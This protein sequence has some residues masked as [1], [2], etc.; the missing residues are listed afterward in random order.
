MRKIKFSKTELSHIYW[1]DQTSFFKPVYDTS[2]TAKRSNGTCKFLKVVE[3]E[4]KYVALFSWRP[5]EGKS[6]TG[7]PG[8]AAHFK[9]GE[10]LEVSLLNMW[11][12]PFRDDYPER[13][14]IKITNAEIIT[15]DNTFWWKYTFERVKVFIIWAPE[16]E[17]VN[18]KGES[19]GM[20]PERALYA[21]AF[22]YVSPDRRYRSDYPAKG[23]GLK[24]LT[25]NSEDQA[26]EECNFVNKVYNDSFIV[27]QIL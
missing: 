17:S 10:I 14:G 6:G 2:L 16:K 13:I 12:S 5:D 9:P 7:I 26:K 23:K 4:G 8:E 21:S 25:F 15:V 22:E 27:K 18:F 3:N 24:L 1:G 11:K 19:L 20:N